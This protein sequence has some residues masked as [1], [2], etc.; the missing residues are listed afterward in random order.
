MT[1]LSRRQR[2]IMRPR[3]SSCVWVQNQYLFLIVNRTLMVIVRRG[4]R[5]Q[6]LIVVYEVVW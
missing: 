2:R 3:A 6:F 4:K 5:F 1:A